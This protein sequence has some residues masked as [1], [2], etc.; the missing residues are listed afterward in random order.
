MTSLSV[1]CCRVISSDS[2]PQWMWFV[3]TSRML[4]TAIVHAETVT[5]EKEK[6]A[7][8]APMRII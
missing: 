2:P 3:Y 8:K 6:R 5:L 7:G 1:T 4:L